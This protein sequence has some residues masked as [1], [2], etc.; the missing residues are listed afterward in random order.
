[1]K[2]IAQAIK[3]II[4]IFC[5]LGGFFSIAEPFFRGLDKSEGITESTKIEQTGLHISTTLGIFKSEEYDYIVFY[6]VDGSNYNCH[7]TGNKIKE[8]K[9]NVRYSKKNPLIGDVT[10]YSGEMWVKIKRSLICFL[11]G[12]F[13]W[14]WFKSSNKQYDE[15]KARLQAHLDRLV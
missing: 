5:L 11:I 14:F 1:M 8:D 3:L 4:I 2:I 10:G 13:M 12:G 6:D 15:K 7:H 9:V